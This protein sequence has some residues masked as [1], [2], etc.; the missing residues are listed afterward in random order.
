MLSPKTPHTRRFFT[1][2][3]ALAR[4]RGA[5]QTN[6]LTIQV[7]AMLRHYEHALLLIEFDPERP[8]ALLVSRGPG[9]TSSEVFVRSCGRHCAEFYPPLLGCRDTGKACQMIL[10]FATQCPN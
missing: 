9:S 6:A 5:A 7:E 3:L 2:I 10:S 4:T 8:F 1:V